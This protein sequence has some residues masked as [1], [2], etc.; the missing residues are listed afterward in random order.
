MN[1]EI[2]AETP[3]FLF[4][5]YLFRN[6]SILSLQCRIPFSLILVTLSLYCE[7]GVAR[8]GE[9]GGGHA[10]GGRPRSTRLQGTRPPPSSGEKS[11]LQHRCQAATRLWRQGNNLF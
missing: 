1:V 7:G 9:P 6:F 10:T 3:I 8:S 11:N 2:G 4:W 5:D